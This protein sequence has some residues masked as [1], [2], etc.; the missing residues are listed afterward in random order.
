MIQK[1]GVNFGAFPSF[2]CSSKDKQKHSENA[3]SINLDHVCVQVC[4]CMCVY[5]ITDQNLIS[6]IVF[7]CFCIKKRKISGVASH[8]LSLRDSCTEN[9]DET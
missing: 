9:V 7:S 2:W 6:K 5:E 4:V 3:L 8:K 1:H